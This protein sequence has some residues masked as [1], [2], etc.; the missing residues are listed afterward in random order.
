MCMR[1]AYNSARLD[2]YAS[3]TYFSGMENARTGN[4]VGALVL[5]LCDAMLRDTQGQ[6]PEPGPAAAAIT[7]LGHEP[8]MPIE[9]LRR[10]LRLSHP[11]AV[12]LVDRL[13]ADGLVVRQPCPSDRRAVALHLTD[14]GDRS[15]AAIL[16]ARE[17]HLA[18]MLD[19]LDRSE[20]ETFGHLAEKLLRGLIQDRDHAYSV[21][22][23][24]D[25]AACVGCPV[26][27]A[28]EV[29]LAGPDPA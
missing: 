4:V 21:C 25:P 13:V 7:L 20:R 9:R 3:R 24:C 17:K 23:L 11:G 8:G 19:I 29:G 2:V 1:G 22:R 5:A 15:C 27:E 18:R 14:A 6:A 26:E 12:R 16:A 28:L 10:A